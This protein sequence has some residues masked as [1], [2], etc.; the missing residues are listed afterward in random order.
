[1]PVAL[2]LLLE[3]FSGSRKKF[4]SKHSPTVRYIDFICPLNGEREV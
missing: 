1:M 3:R 2:W 4:A